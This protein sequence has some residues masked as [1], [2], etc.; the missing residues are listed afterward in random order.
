M[1]ERHCFRCGKEIPEGSLNYLVN[2][3]IFSGFDD[4][5][6]EPEEEVDEDLKHILEEI[7]QLDPQELENEVYEEFSLLLCKSC[8]DR[9]VAETRYP[10]EGPFRT[11]RDPSPFIH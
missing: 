7:E 6:L 10:W 3:R 5:I 1:G 4:L 9:F 2:I 11:K 8:R